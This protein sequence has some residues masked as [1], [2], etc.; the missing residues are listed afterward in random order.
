MTNAS[1][2]QA[3]THALERKPR[4]N[5]KATTTSTDPGRVRIVLA[6]TAGDMQERMTVAGRARPHLQV[7]VDDIVAVQ[8]MEAA[9]HVKRDAP[10]SAGPDTVQHSVDAAPHARCKPWCYWRMYIKYR[11]SR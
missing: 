11:A 4:V 3:E 7:K 2:E 8:I 6:R 1:D 10:T 5:L 9:C